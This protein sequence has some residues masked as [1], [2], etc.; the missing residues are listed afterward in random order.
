MKVA[1]IIKIIGEG[2]NVAIVARKEGRDCDR[3]IYEYDECEFFGDNGCEDC[4]HVLKITVTWPLFEGKAEDVPIK[5]AGKQVEKIRA[6]F[7]GPKVRRNSKPCI[8]IEVKP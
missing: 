7:T 4:D 2:E 1:D 6:M 8:E 3:D 5:L